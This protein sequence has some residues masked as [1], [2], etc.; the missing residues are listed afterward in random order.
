M[1][2]LLGVLICFRWWQSLPEQGTEVSDS[3]TVAAKVSLLKCGWEEPLVADFWTCLEAAI[4]LTLELAGSLG[5]A[6]SCGLQDAQ[7]PASQGQL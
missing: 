1:L 6:G 7:D 4:P 3:P 2:S 5:L